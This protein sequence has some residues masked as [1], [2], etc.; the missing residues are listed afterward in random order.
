MAI[1]RAMRRWTIAMVALLATWSLLAL[2]PAVAQSFVL[3]QRIELPSVDGRIDHMDIDVDGSRLFVAE[4]G[5]GSVEV[6]DL[7]AGKRIARIQSLHEPQ[8]VLFV[9]VP[10][11]GGTAAGIRAYKVE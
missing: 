2:Q 8:G 5:A 1:S 3:A 11:H 10:S 6:V 9:A 7:Q 4:L